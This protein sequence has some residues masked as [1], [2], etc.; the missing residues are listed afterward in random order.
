MELR[1]G[2]PDLGSIYVQLRK[3]PTLELWIY[4]QVNWNAAFGAECT[5]HADSKATCFRE[6]NVPGYRTPWRGYRYANWLETVT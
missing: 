5:E 3:Q 6:E 2:L 4:I 1:H